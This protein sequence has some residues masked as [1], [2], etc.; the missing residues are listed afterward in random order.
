MKRSNKRCRSKEWSKAR[1]CIAEEE[2]L[3]EMR[4]QSTDEQDVMSGFE[5][6][7]TDRRSAGLARGEMRGVGR[8]RPA[9]KA[10]AKGAE[11]RENTEAKEDLAAKAQWRM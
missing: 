6:V 3:Q 4:A 8:T 11:E 2:Q 9:G 5:E 1:K 7:R 10:K